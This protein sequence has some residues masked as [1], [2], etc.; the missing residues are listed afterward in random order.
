MMYIARPKNFKEWVPK[1]YEKINK[2]IESCRTKAQLKASK[3]MVDN[4][5][6]I[7]ALEEDASTNQIESIALQFWTRINLKLINLE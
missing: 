4:F 3:Q 6:I 2:T 1:A 7:L 5:I